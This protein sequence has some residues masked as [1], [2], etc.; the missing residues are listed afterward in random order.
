[1]IEALAPLSGNF[2]PRQTLALRTASRDKQPESANGVVKE[3][4]EAETEKAPDSN[5][6]QANGSGSSILEHPFLLLQQT[7]SAVESR[8]FSSESSAESLV[9]EAL[10]LIELEL[11]GRDTE[12]QELKAMPFNRERAEGVSAIE[13]ALTD[14]QG[15]MAS[16][17]DLDQASSHQCDWQQERARHLLRILQKLK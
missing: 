3:A 10:D 5:T 12:I 8:P 9:A 13:L 1:M 17:S 16:F 11:T 2:E 6:Q 15:R 7:A 14:V 4:T